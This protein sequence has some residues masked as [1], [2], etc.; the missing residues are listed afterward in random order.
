MSKG[1]VVLRLKGR[2]EKYFLV[3]YILAA[4]TSESFFLF[5]FRNVFSHVQLYT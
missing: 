3:Y 4:V 1:L 5:F 2:V